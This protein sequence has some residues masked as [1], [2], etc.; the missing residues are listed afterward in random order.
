MSASSLVNGA[1]TSSRSER[2]WPGMIV[3]FGFWVGAQSGSG[4]AVFDDSSGSSGAIGSF[5]PG[6]AGSGTSTGAG[7]ALS[8]CGG[9]AGATSVVGVGGG[10]ADERASEDAGVSTGIVVL[11][12]TR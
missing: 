5:G 4:S 7:A 10:A 6:R 2:I 3:D 1:G 11:G 9:V 12:A 8:G